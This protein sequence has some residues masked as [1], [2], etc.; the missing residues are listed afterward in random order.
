MSSPC[1]CMCLRINIV[2]QP[3]R[4][5]PVGGLPVLDYASVATVDVLAIPQLKRDGIGC[6]ADKKLNR[7]PYP[8][9]PN[10]YTMPEATESELQLLEP[11]GL[12]STIAP[13][14]V[15]APLI[16]QSEG[17][18]EPSHATLE[19]TALR[20]TLWTVLSYGA[21]QAL[22]VVN[23]LV[24]THL[25]LPSAFGEMSLV[26]T[27]IV[28]MTLLSDL[29]LGPSIIQSKRGDEPDFLNTAWTLQ[30]LRGVLLWLIAVALAVPA[31]HFYHDPRLIRVFPV[32]AL[33]MIV[34]G[35]NSTGLLTLSRHMG[36]RRL[37]AIEFSTQIVALAITVGWA[38]RWPSVW[39]LVAGT[40]TSCLYRLAL[41]HHPSTMAGHRNRFTLNREC[42]RDILKFGKWIVLG[43]ALYF[44]ASQ[45]DRLILGSYVSMAT[46]GIYGIAFQIS[47]VPR[48]VINAF[49]AKVGFPFVSKMIHR[50]MPEFRPQ[51][52]RYRSYALLLGAVL[53]AA[54]AI[55][56]PFVIL[57]LY[58]ARYADAAWMIPILALGLWHT[59]LYTTTSPVLLALG[60]SSYN[61]VG[62]AAYAVAM[63]GGIPLAWHLGN[64][65][66]RGQGLFWAVVAIAAGDFPLY[67]VTQFGAT[68]EGVRPL[69]QDALLTGAFLACLGFGWGLRHFL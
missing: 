8:C 17:T 51:F 52:L 16:E 27:L 69:R 59:L 31:A 10:V 22:R 11:Q 25:L 4:A 47:D 41:S 14:D 32:L 65:H 28:G 7:F 56:G 44:F 40:V 33:T 26:T 15:Y 68:R 12:D 60:K 18:K 19:A 21:S 9:S 49:S 34:T 57:R 5:L 29:G 67:L 36:V 23:S 61:A 58:P 2:Y 63:L 38:Y 48:S 6:P 30:V 55:W 66:G 43:T 20:A 54:M 13:E 37:F 53:L 35:F 50:P 42:I 24:L 46:L 3:S 64:E 39:A 45:A 62:N 1:N